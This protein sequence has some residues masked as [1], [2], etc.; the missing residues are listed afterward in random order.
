MLLKMLNPEYII[1][2]HGDINKKASYYNIASD[3]EI[4]WEKI[5]FS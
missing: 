2:N 4:H 3:Y 5:Y 1:P